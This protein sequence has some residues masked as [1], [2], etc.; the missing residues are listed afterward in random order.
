[1]AIDFSQQVYAPTYAVFSRPVEF[2]PKASQPGQ[3]VYTGRGIFSTQPM[4]VLTEDN[5][6]LSDA[7]TILDIIEIEFNVLPEQLDELYIPAS[8]GMPALGNFQVM[9]VDLNGG[10]EATLTLR[11]LVASKP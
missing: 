4:D 9:N 11:R 5:A 8:E 3:P 7:K 6:I 10:G 2:T 1:V